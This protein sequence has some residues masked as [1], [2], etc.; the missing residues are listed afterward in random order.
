M[1]SFRPNDRQVDAI[2]LRP[3]SQRG[4]IGRIERKVRC[5]GSGS[6]IAARD[7]QLGIRRIVMQFPEQRVL[8]PATSDH[9]N[10]HCFFHPSL[11]A[12]RT[13]FAASPN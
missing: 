13:F 11:N 10:L 2:A 4:C 7:E 6:A 9:Q 5:E 8:A 3:C 12:S 1:G